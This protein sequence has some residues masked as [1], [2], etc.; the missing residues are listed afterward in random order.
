MSGDVEPA[1]HDPSSVADD[2]AEA[3]DERQGVRARARALT[4]WLIRNQASIDG[5]LTTSSN[6]LSGSLLALNGGAAVALSQ[7]V[8]RVE[9]P[10]L[11]LG[12]L[13]A[14]LFFA[15]LSPVIIQ[16]YAARASPSVG[17]RVI[18]W[19][20]VAVGEPID[21]AAEAE[22]V[23]QLDGLKWMTIASPAA[24]WISGLL[25]FVAIVTIAYGFDRDADA[26]NARCASIQRDMLS[27]HPKRADSL[28]L[29]EVLDCKPVARTSA[30]GLSA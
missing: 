17:Q 27:A 15:M 13:I 1:I 22:W 19:A 21:E 6:W 12:L 20:G 30:S 8:D 10:R 5:Q 23:R 26:N 2:L 28:R 18:H 16:S 4:D 24:G 3:C 9:Y 25:F 29:F 7:L 14:G 11:A